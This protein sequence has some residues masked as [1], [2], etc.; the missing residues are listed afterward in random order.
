MKLCPEGKATVR[1]SV[2][3]KLGYSFDHFTGIF[4]TRKR[5]AYYLCYDYGF[6]PILEKGIEKVLIIGRQKFM[7]DWDPWRR[8]WR[9]ARPGK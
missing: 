2:L 6:L 1:K 7:N 5:E 3:V 4:V 9:I 8:L